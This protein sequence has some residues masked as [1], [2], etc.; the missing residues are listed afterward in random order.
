[1]ILMMNVGFSY[2]VCGVGYCCTERV[3]AF[4][5]MIF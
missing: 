5:A 2:C 1:M 3:G 4:F